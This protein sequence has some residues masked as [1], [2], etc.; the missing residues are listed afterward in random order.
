M[1]SQYIVLFRASALPKSNK[2]IVFRLVAYLLNMVCLI[3]QLLYEIWYIYVMV[4][5]WHSFISISRD[6]NIRQMSYMYRSKPEVSWPLRTPFHF[7]F[8]VPLNLHFL[9]LQNKPERFS[10]S[11]FSSFDLY[12]RFYLNV[13]NK[14]KLIE[15]IFENLSEPADIFGGNRKL[16]IHK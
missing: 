13:T 9:T 4:L 6:S 11:C 12:L 3:L 15:K 1:G 8:T 2:Y 14:S 7:S 5:F 16:K 10:N